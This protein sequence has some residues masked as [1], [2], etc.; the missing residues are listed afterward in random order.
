MNRGNQILAGVLALQAVILIGMNLGGDDPMVVEQKKLFADL[1]G[2]LVTRVEILGPPGEEQESIVLKRSGSKWGIETADGYP[3]KSEEVKELLET[4]EDLRSTSLVVT[5]DRYHEKLKVADDDY[6]RLVKLTTDGGTIEM[7]VG[8]SPSFKN[9]HVR[10]GGSDDVFLVPELSTSDV[11]ERAWNWVDRYYLD[12]PQDEVWSVEIENEKGTIRLERD[13]VS[14]DWAAVGVEGEL[15][16]STVDD[17]VRKARSVKLEAPVGKTVKPEFGLEDPEATVRLVVG[18]STIAG[19]PPKTTE[20]RTL[21]V[22]AKVEGKSR[23][24]AKAETNEYVVEVAEYA[25]T[26]LLEKGREDLRKKEEE[27]KKKKKGS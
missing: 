2:D 16:T 8:T 20:T 3:A 6:N 21:R 12:V 15:N 7:Y 11:T 9:T 5:S 24:Y 13:P 19:A 18:T 14:D 17:L 23:Y 27:K 22:G 1:D 25:V 26:P 10:I 4:I